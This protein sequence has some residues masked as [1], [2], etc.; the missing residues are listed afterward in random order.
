MLIL[1]A[2]MGWGCHNAYI[3]ISA[4]AGFRAAGFVGGL[5]ARQENDHRS[6]AG[7]SWWGP[8]LSQ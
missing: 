7:G 1:W 8:W 3:N 5:A 4:K 2:V 6:N